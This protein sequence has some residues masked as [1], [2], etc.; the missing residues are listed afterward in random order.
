[1]LY[2]SEF[3]T[4]ILKRYNFLLPAILTITA[5]FT[6]IFAKI[7]VAEISPLSLGFLRF[8]F[9]AL[10]FLIT[11]LVTGTNL[12]FENKDYIKLILLGALGIPF[13]QF[14]FL[15]GI[16]MSYASHSGVIFSLNPVFAYIAAIAQGHEKFY[17]SKIFAIM[18]TV[19]GIFFVFYEAV[20]KEGAGN[21]ATGDLLLVLAVMSFSLYIALGKKFIDKYGTL[22]VTAF[23]FI[24]GS[25][26]DI[27]V[28]LIDMKNLDLEKVT[29]SGITGFLY[30]S[31]I[32]SYAAYFLWYYTLK[33]IKI[34]MLTTITNL[35][36]ILTVL[37]SVILLNER[38]SVL[39]VLGACI[40]VIGVLVMQRVSVEL[41]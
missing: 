17:R 7:T 13:N 26:L 4:F 19:I 5:S 28:F 27:P 20:T 32:M 34:S 41:T 24:A 18:L 3:T 14:C 11:I 21:L 37:A 25:I 8:G 38:I 31:V 9:A 2:G 36:P 33:R 30:L 29:V 23:V 12:R 1:L 22:K 39:F 6:P 16:S 15:K 40:T 35:A 10:L